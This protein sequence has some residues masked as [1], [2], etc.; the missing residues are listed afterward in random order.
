MKACRNKKIQTNSTFNLQFVSNSSSIKKDMADNLNES[1]SDAYYEN[2]S[3]IS[4]LNSVYAR[5]Q[6]IPL[7]DNYLPVTSL[8]EQQKPEN[9]NNCHSLHPLHLQ[10][11]RMFQQPSS[12]NV[13]YV[14]DGGGCCS[15]GGGEE[16]RIPYDVAT[17][18]NYP[19]AQYM[20]TLSYQ[21][22]TPH[23]GYNHHNVGRDAPQ[24]PNSGNSFDNNSINGYMPPVAV[25]GVRSNFIRPRSATARDPVAMNQQVRVN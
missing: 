25:G 4:E 18:T 8:D 10:S 12:N 5:N 16:P 6:T 2:D 14:S 9:F 20:D 19:A 21:P 11:N 15:G 24:F 13:K 17:T 3:T 23:Y 22:S 1:Y 7:V